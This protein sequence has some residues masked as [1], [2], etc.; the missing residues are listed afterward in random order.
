MGGWEE[1]KKESKKIHKAFI[2]L[3][4]NIPHWIE[5]GLYLSISAGY[6]RQTWP[7]THI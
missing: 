6:L 2:E 4:R 7:M 5:A 3:N 1:K